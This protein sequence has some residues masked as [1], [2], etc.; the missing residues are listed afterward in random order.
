[1]RKLDRVV[2]QI[3]EDLLEAL[4]VQAE[5][6][7]C[8]DFKLGLERDVAHHCFG[9]H[10][11]C[12]VNYALLDVDWLRILQTKDALLEHVLIEQ[13]LSVALKEF[14]RT[15]DHVQKLNLLRRLLKIKEFGAEVDYASDGVEH[16][17]GNRSRVHLQIL[18]HL[19]DILVA[20]IFRDVSNGNVLAKSIVKVDPLALNVDE[21]L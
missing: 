5:L 21:L 3:E 8:W 16:L 13:I 1:M 4:L 12:Y 18:V 20:D 10:Q 6:S 9:N 15:V 14:C 11:L 2:N 19:F 7:I 17:S